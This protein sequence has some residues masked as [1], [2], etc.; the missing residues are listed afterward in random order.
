MSGGIV[1][2]ASVCSKQADVTYSVPQATGATSFRWT[3][4]SMAVIKSGQGTNTIRVTFATKGG[5]VSVTVTNAC[6]TTAAQT[7]AVAVTTCGKQ[8]PGMSAFTQEEE[9]V[10]QQIKA[11]PNPAK[12]LVTV[13]FGA[14]VAGKYQLTVSDGV[15]KIV[16]ND[17]IFIQGKTTSLDL[18]ALARGL[19]T[20]SV[21]DGLKTSVV[22]IV[23][24]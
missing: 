5:N 2:P 21:S 23:L 12:G 14:M 9:L 6:G 24:Q 11:Y 15:G 20:I 3:V 8:R 1:G 22:K 17:K 7:L 19:Y 4:P 18:S 10:V 13:H 16:R